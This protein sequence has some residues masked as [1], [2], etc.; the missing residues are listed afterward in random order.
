[1]LYKNLLEKTPKNG[2]NNWERS[3]NLLFNLPFFLKSNL[4][5]DL[6][7][8]IS[9]HFLNSVSIVSLQRCYEKNFI[10]SYELLP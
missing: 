7:F 1:M 2:Q 4:I 8:I 5:L 9:K 10:G 3:Q 6:F